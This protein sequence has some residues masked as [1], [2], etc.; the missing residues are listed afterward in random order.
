MTFFSR[1]NMALQAAIAAYRDP[2]GFPGDQVISD[3]RAY[4]HLLW[5]Y[6]QNRAF[7]D[8]AIWQKYRENFQLYR[9]I[10]SIYNPTRRLV[11]FYV[12]QVYPGVLSEDASRLPD[13]VQLA[14]PLSDDTDEDLKVAIAQFWQWSNWQSGNRLMVRFGSAVGSCLVEVIDDEERGKVSASVVWPGKLAD[15][16]KDDTPSLVL[17]SSGN[18][19]FYALEYSATDE[20]GQSFIFRKEIS[21]ESFRYYKN[22]TLMDEIENPYGFVPAVWC[23][24]VDEGDDFGSPAIA[25]SI[26]KIDE[27]NGLVSHDHDNVDIL[28]DSPGIIAADAKVGTIAQDAADRK[29]SASDE[30]SA[31]AGLKEKPTK[32]L[33]LKGPKDTSWVPLI[34]NLEPDKVV[35]LIDHLLGE[36]EHDFPEL[37]MYQ[38]LRKM[39]Q[40]TGPA[41]SRMMGDVYSRVLEVSSNYDQQSI[42]LF[43]MACAIGG[44]RLRQ[45]QE[46]WRDK[47]EQRRKFASF[48]LESYSR[49]DLDMAI[50]PRPLIP[51]T[52]ADTVEMQGKRLDNAGKAKDIFS[53][54]KVLE[55]AGISDESERRRM[56][57]EREQEATNQTNNN[58]GQLARQAALSAP[59]GVRGLLGS[60]Q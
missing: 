24:H 43:Q 2:D 28:I 39:S 35:P 8:L 20:K 3:R 34:G 56:L 15:K 4:L 48:N 58:L 38:E 47:T 40:V 33:L 46:G 11:N 5:R 21:Q 30:Y 45:G 10:R 16:A 57:A 31:T 37:S 19:K 6:Y 26:G 55:V 13:G 51:M 7:D 1:L 14:I 27:L 53:P 49:G 25:G 44:F 32:R 50:M 41:A 36:I 60:G 52:E 59:A 12:A 42:K 18:V 29:V 22:E 54:E 23:K 17:D 9:N